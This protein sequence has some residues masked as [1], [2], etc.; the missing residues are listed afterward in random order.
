MGRMLPLG[1]I[2]CGLSLCSG[3]GCS[4]LQSWREKSEESDVGRLREERREE[5]VHN[6]ERRRLE[7]QLQLARERAEQGDPESAE[8]ILQGT[9]KRDPSSVAAREQ[10]AELYW[11][12]DQFAEAEHQ[13]R[14]ALAI[15]PKRADLHYLLGLLLDGRGNAP[16]ARLYFAKAVE[17]EPTNDLFRATA[18]SGGAEPPMVAHSGESAHSAA[19]AKPE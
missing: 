11:A 17:L 15:V 18:E 5:V 9:L 14:D 13:L 1:L 10:L 19:A 4:A 2:L 8:E 7:A 6:F 16:E 3:A 12:H